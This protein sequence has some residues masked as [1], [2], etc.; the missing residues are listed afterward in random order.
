M[1]NALITDN[2]SIGFYQIGVANNDEA[3]IPQYIEHSPVESC[4]NGID[5]NTNLPITT[6]FFSITDSRL[7]GM[8]GFMINMTFPEIHGEG[9]FR[10]IEYFPFRLIREFKIMIGKRV[11]KRMSGFEILQN[12]IAICGHRYNKMYGHDTRFYKYHKGYFR[13]DI[14][15]KSF[16]VSLPIYVS[17]D[18]IVPESICPVVPGDLNLTLDLYPISSVMIVVKKDIKNLDKPN[19]L[20]DVTVSF[21]HYSSTI[22]I[23]K[24]LCVEDVIFTDN[25][26]NNESKIITNQFTSIT[27]IGYTV[28]TDNFINKTFVCYPEGIRSI[29]SYKQ[30][31]ERALVNDIVTCFDEDIRCEK[32]TVDPNTHEMGC[33]VK[34]ILENKYGPLH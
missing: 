29:A 32:C 12:L 31:Y 2:N 34:R 22:P 21:K 27:S 25:P 33:G 14:V 10:Y 11:I 18:G 1:N 9:S 3:S 17:W 19:D 24:K 13:D 7:E 20:S 6:K 23:T 28:R 8:S 15:S 16:T 5:H 26:Y 30:A 4:K